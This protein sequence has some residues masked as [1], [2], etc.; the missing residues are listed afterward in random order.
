MSEPLTDAGRQTTGLEE[1]PCFALTTVDE[2]TARRDALVERLLEA[3]VQTAEV[4]AVYLGDR[5]GFY[6]ALADLGTATSTQLSAH[7]QTDERYTREWLE[8]QAVAGILQVANRGDDARTRRYCLPP[9]HAEALL[10]ENS[11]E[12][13]APFARQVAGSVR[14]LPA[15]LEAFRSGGGVPWSAYGA[16]VREGQA[17]GN[18]PA[19]LR[20]L[21]SDWFPAIPEVHARLQADPPARVA[22]V[23]C[24]A[25]WS[26]IAI[27]RAYP[28]VS[29][30]GFDSDDVAI[31]MARENAQQA[32]VARRLR[33][34]AGNAAGLSQAGEYDLVTVFEALHDMAQPVAALRSIRGLLTPGGSV[35]VMDEK[36]PAAFEAPGGLTD[37]LFYGFSLLVCLPASM[38]EQP[39]AATGTVMRPDTLRRYAAEAGFAD[40]EILPVEHFLWRFYRLVP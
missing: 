27:A 8:H 38:A 10:D 31:E 7:A 14:Q 35:I 33:F 1:R 11:L 23:G 19:F 21:A 40:V 37:R 9:G 18:R 12:W 30:D 26:S 32:G 34:H 16:D 24:G 3:C 17:D 36:V 15:L 29:V 22:D 2:E 39:S 6:Q 25:G 5:L 13:V 20:L 4:A 28:K